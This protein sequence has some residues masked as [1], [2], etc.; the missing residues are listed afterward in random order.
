MPN[1]NRTPSAADLRL[2]LD[3]AVRPKTRARIVRL[4]QQAEAQSRRPRRAARDYEVEL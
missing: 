4:L 2:R 3:Q 1:P